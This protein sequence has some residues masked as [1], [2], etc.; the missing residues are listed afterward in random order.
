MTTE[1]LRQQYMRLYDYMASEQNPEYMKAFGKVM[2]E[3]FDWFAANKKEAAEEW[4]MKLEAIK[5]DNYLTKA[6][7]EAIVADMQPKAP[8]TMEVW[9]SAMDAKGLPLDD[10]PCYNSYA[11]WVEM[12]KQYSDS[13]KTIAIIMGKNLEDVTSDEMVNATY[14]LALDMLTD[15][16]NVY[17]I[18]RYFDV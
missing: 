1:E 15:E 5:W 10:E 2:T 18:R 7:A 11:L 4:L 3:M 9:K 14:H 12:N 6:E 8:W 16:D 17:N 13:A